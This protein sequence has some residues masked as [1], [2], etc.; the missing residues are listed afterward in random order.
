MLSVK[1]E[2]AEKIDLFYVRK[3]IIRLYYL[4]KSGKRKSLIYLNKTTT[5]YY[6]THKGFWN[7]IIDDIKYYFII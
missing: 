3:Y 4:S 5:L 6:Y 1:N 7:Y 2:L